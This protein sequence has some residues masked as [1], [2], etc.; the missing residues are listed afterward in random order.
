MLLKWIFSLVF[1]V[2]C[3]MDL[4]VCKIVKIDNNSKYEDIKGAI[5]SQAANRRTD[6][7]MTK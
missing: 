6:N 7:A 5:I 4:F 2:D 3:V 1:N